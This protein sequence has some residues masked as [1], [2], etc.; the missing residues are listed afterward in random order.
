MPDG[1]KL[2][3]GDNGPG[4]GPQIQ[5]EHRVDPRY[6]DTAWKIISC[7]R[8]MTSD[9]R[10]TA[11]GG[12]KVVVPTVF[13]FGAPYRGGTPSVEDQINWKFE[14]LHELRLPVV[15]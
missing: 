15:V 6:H 1:S 10:W 2:L 3:D 7:I 13:H 8:R 12:Y 14:V 9:A 4:D 5:P 11:R